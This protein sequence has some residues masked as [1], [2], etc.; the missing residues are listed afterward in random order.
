MLSI[1]QSIIVFSNRK[2]DGEWQIP[3]LIQPESTASTVADDDAFD[4]LGCETD[5]TTA[6]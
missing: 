4:N 6:C 3:L 5:V 1:N 2:A